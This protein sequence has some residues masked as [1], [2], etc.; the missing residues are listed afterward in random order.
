MC[1]TIDAEV[2]GREVDILLGIK[3]VKYF[4]LLVYSLP[5]GLQIYRAVLKSDSPQPGSVAGV[6]T[7]R[8][9]G[10]WISRST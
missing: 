8:G 5:G 3:Y 9:A 6:R 4:P 2:G 10:C 1:V 7:R